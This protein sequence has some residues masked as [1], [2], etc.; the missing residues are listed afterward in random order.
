MWLLAM[1]F[2]AAAVRLPHILSDGAVLEQSSDVRLW[3]WSDRPGKRLTVA[4]SWGERRKK[5]KNI[6]SSIQH[7]CMAFY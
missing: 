1:P 5:Q 3:G 2:A 7:L 4:A 6:F